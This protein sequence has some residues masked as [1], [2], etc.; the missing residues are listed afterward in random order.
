MKIFLWGGTGQ[1]LVLSE[2]LEKLGYELFA[3][4]DRNT[5]LISPLSNIPIYHEYNDFLQNEQPSPH[6]TAFAVSIGG[7]G[8]FDRLK[9]HACLEND[10][11]K[12]V[13]L[14]HPTAYIAH[15]ATLG[16][17]NQILLHS[18]ICANVRIG[19]QCIVNTNASID[20][21]CFLGNGIHICP[22]ATLL[23]DV[24]I[25]D[26]AMIGAGAIIFPH[27][28]IGAS[29]IIGAGAVV[30][31]NVDSETIVVGNPARFLKNT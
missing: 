8:G 2:F 16:T 15:N 28:E 30:R 4:I 27:V 31:K 6:S 19:N 22:G 11:F 18:S 23:G 13:N 26:Y 20:H 14:I 9:I 3:I 24:T 21:E 17:G 12:S 1:A 10:G 29:A 7:Y 5:N 25:H